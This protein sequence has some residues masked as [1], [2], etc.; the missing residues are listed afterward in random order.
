MDPVS[1]FDAKNRLSALLDQVE[2]G[3]EI[4]ITR[5]GKAVA[6]LV[7]TSIPDR[8][9]MAVE[10]LRVLREGI[11]GRGERF[12]WTDLKGYRDEGRR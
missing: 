2:R 3:H 11:A 6:R 7:P 5:R 1:V 10:K 4:V 9:H 12:A 8:P